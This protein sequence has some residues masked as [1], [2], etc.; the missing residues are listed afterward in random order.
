LPNNVTEELVSK[1]YEMGWS[2]GCKGMTVY[3]DGSRQG[4]IM[5]NEGTQNVVTEENNSEPRPK[6]LECE[7]VRFTN[8]KEKWVGFL[9]LKT[10]IK[11]QKY[12]YELFTGLAD[13]FYIPPSI[14]KGEIVRFKIDGSS[15]YDFV[16]KDKD[17]YNIT[18]EGLSRA[19]NREFWNYSKL[20]SA[21]LRHRMHLP[22]VIKI[23][24]GLQMDGDKEA[25]FGT[26]KSGVKRI[27]KKYINSIVSGEA[28]PECGNTDLVYETG[29]KTCKNCGWS[30]CS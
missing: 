7:V 10:D 13:E 1:V 30:K 3:R 17:G 22:S 24:D 16:Y 20:V 8:N 29:C 4:V 6:R 27:I 28:C 14:E 9:G 18:M 23:I 2:S 5:S 12:P 25:A 11:D 26:W 19:F 15:R 21:L